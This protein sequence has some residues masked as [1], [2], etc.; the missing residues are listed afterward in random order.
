[1][2]G[3]ILIVSLVLL[4]VF[5]VPWRKGR[6]LRCRGC[7]YVVEGLAAQVC[8]EC[9]RGLERKGAVR[10]G[11]RRRQW[12]AGVLG[13]VGLYRTLTAPGWEHRVPAWWLIEV[14]TRFAAGPRLHTAMMGVTFG[15]RYGRFTD[16]DDDRASVVAFERVWRM[17]EKSV[18]VDPLLL[19]IAERAAVGGHVERERVAEVVQRL[20]LPRLA[21]SP[22]SVVKVG[23]SSLLQVRP[24]FLPWGWSVRY[25]Y[26][27]DPGSSTSR[28]TGHGERGP[29]GGTH[30]SNWGQFPWPKVATAKGEW[31]VEVIAPEETKAVSTRRFSMNVR[32]E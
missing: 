8:P 13:L 12:W 26:T 29:N 28:C 11:L 10:R 6:E 22:N 3:A 24:E 27:I 23:S 15:K 21:L 32:L 30:S 25:A 5:A 2:I 9:G 18:N 19:I 1:V 31:V 16:R 14:E 7:G 20:A 17:T 4:V